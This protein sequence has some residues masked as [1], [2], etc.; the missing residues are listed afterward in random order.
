[1]IWLKLRAAENVAECAVTPTIR[2]GQ[3]G[4]ARS[5]HA[6]R[7]PFV[8]FA[9]P[10]DL[11]SIPSATG[12]IARLACARMREAGKGMATVLSGAGLTAA[13]LNDRG[14]RLEVRTQIKVLDLAARELDDECLGFHLARS[15]DLR[16]IGLLYYVMASSE[17]LQDALRNAE[18]YSGI[19]NEGVRLRFRSDRAAVVTLDY[20]NVDRNL[21]RHQIEF[22]L[23][24]VVRLCRQL[25]GNRLAPRKLTVRHVRDHTPAEY[26]SFLG[27]DV[28]FGADADEIVFAA[29]AASLPLVGADLYLNRLLRRYADEALHDRPRPSKGVR[30]HV[31]A[32]LPQLLPHGKATTSEVARRLGLSRRTLSRSL[33]AEGVT[34]TRILEELRATLARH[35][36]MDRELPVTEIAWLLGYREIGSFTH[37]FRRWTGISP[38]QFRSSGRARGEGNGRQGRKPR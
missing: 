19:N 37:A 12:G 31:E 15:F 30:A 13:Q 10:S 33:A 22:W 24:T 3:H 9:R 17:L 14:L 18:R 20:H 23:I 36:L 29:Q 27:N 28:Q 2:A 5:L 38:S 6:K 4:E 34:F 25:T 8:R 21:D 7:E 32:V 16:E 26:K 1:L 35:Y 11:R